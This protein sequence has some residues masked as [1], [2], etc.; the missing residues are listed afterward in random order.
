[1][2]K[3]TPS[4]GHLYEYWN[5]MKMKAEQEGIELIPLER[6]IFKHEYLR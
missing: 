3:K 4:I 5:I 1:M 2:S 6:Q